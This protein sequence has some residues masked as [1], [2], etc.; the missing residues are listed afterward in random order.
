[1]VLCRTPLP[2][3]GG[4]LPNQKALQ[5][6]TM[7]NSNGRRNRQPTPPGRL[8]FIIFFF[9]PSLW[10]VLTAVKPIEETMRVPPVWIPEQMGG[11]FWK[12][13]TYGQGS[14]RLHPT[15]VYAR[16][17]SHLYPHS[18]LGGRL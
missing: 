6:A 5:P 14:A 16:T 13:I 1:M 11:H 8:C 3:A 12:A 9:L 7:T 18:E 2:P 10:V 17:R 4:N 15:L